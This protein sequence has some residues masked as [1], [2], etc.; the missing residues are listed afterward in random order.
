METSTRR[1]HKAQQPI[2]SLPKLTTLV[3]S[4]PLSNSIPTLLLHVA[5][6]LR[7]LDLKISDDMTRLLINALMVMAQ[8]EELTIAMYEAK[9]DPYNVLPVPV[10]EAQAINTLRS[11]SLRPQFRVIPILEE[12]LSSF[13]IQAFGELIF[14]AC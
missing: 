1:N 10:G 5:A 9:H 2:F 4:Q 12:Q 11:L 3:Y 8:L 6:N 14:G 7:K 13:C